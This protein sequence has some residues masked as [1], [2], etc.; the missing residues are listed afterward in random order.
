M[1]KRNVPCHEG[2]SSVNQQNIPD[3]RNS[4]WSRLALHHRSPSLPH[5]SHSPLPFSCPINVIGLYIWVRFP[6]PILPFSWVLWVTL[7]LGMI[8]CC[9][10]RQA[11]RPWEPTSK[12]LPSPPRKLQLKLK[13][14]S[15]AFHAKCERLKP[16]DGSQRCSRRVIS[17]T[18][19]SLWVGPACEWAPEVS[20]SGLSIMFCKWRK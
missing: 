9:W 1:R 13:H 16:P 7:F 4:L 5:I 18:P 2:K 17:T 3:F 19:P 8:H 11:H 10:G 15:P 6:L 20:P 12:T 14:T